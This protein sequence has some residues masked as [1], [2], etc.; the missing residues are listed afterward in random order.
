MAAGTLAERGFDVTLTDK[1]EKTGKKLYITGK[2]R[3]NV[4]N[5]CDA[6]EFLDNVVSNPKFLMSAINSFDSFKTIDFLQ[7]N[8]LNVVTERGNRVFPASGKS[9]DVIKTF[10]DFCLKNGVKIVLGQKV[11]SVEADGESFKVTFEKHT[12]L[13]DK[14]IIATGGLSYPST[15][16]TGDGYKIA[17]SFGHKIVN[18]VQALV[19]IEL[20]EDYVKDLAGLSLKNVRVTAFSGEKELCSEFGEML[21]THKGVSGPIVLSMS[22]KLNRMPLSGVTLSVDLKPALTEEILDARL[23]RDFKELNNKQFKNS[24][25]SLLPKSLIPLVV[26][27]SGINPEQKVGQIPREKRKNL[28]KLLK[29]LTFSVK[30]LAGFE[31][32]IVTAGGVNVKEINPKTMESKLQP[33][34]Y[35]IGEVLDVDAFTG[36]FNIQIALATA[37]ACATHL[38]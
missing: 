7:K 38:S 12:E 3:C 10:T 21:F 9:S 5:E 22:S 19:P 4:T 32:A 1:N 16:S 2:G 30:K 6:K 24:L 20:K 23:E 29:N 14:V 28:T 34:L 25:D 13:F 8:G 37:Y 11:L 15:G 26:K 33:G 36:G 17:R 35:F 27:L 31:E 18:P